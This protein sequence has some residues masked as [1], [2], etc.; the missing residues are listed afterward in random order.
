MQI[1]ALNRIKPKR[2]AIH[3]TILETINSIYQQNFQESYSFYRMYINYGYLRFGPRCLI[4]VPI[5]H[6]MMKSAK[7]KKDCLPF[8][9]KF[10]YS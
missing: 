2:D 1:S 10:D 7:L 4:N 6:T 5:H 3:V 9:K 8:Q